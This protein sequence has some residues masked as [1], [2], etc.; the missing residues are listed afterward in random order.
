[1][2][3]R[4]ASCS[5]DD[6]PETAHDFRVDIVVTPTEVIR[7]KARRRKGRIDWQDL[8]DEQIAAIPALAA[9]APSARRQP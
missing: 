2:L 9:R 1:M 3:S 8:D 4:T 6:L 5:T 7:T